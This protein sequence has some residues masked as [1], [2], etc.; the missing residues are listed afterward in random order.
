[1]LN[2]SMDQMDL[3]VESAVREQL[4]PLYDELLQ[5]MHDLGV[6]PI[7]VNADD[8]RRL[9]EV[10]DQ[11]RE[12][13]DRWIVAHPSE[14]EALY[15]RCPD[16]CRLPSVSASLLEVGTWNTYFAVR[17][18]DLAPGW[19]GSRVMAALP[20][21]GARIDGDGLVDVAGLEATGHGL[22]IGPYAL[23]YHRVLR[24]GFVSNVHYDLV[25]LLLASAAADGLSLRLAVDEGRLRLR[26][27]Y[28]ERIER[29]FWYGP[30]Y[31]E[32]RLDDPYLTG[33]TYFA[34]P[35]GGASIL[36]PY[37]GF[38]VRTAVAGS[39]KTL[40]IE[41]FVPVDE[42][43]PWALAR[44]LHAI[45]DMDRK[46]FTH[47]DGAVKAYPSR[48]YP[49][50][51]NGFKARPK[52]ELYRKAFRLDGLIPTDTWTNVLTSWFRGNTLALEYLA[53]TAGSSVTAVGPTAD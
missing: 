40:Q 41:E 47:C 44:Y 31:N 48:Q 16:V 43:Q 27:E 23:H 12:R 1:M 26:D 24:R 29:D 49:D 10:R 17:K 32:G 20:E 51:L 38:S 42:K 14:A 50:T 21:L 25:A 28:E 18:S 22:F 53:D 45:R 46:A 36:M 11:A 4:G 39:L 9:I 33:E 37:V 15:R 6:P 2:V 19:P 8:R 5:V 30:P 13:L 34:E 3:A 35:T 7:G 52:S